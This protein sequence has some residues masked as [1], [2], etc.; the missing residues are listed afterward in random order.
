MPFKGVVKITTFKNTL[1]GAPSDFENNCGFSYSRPF[2]FG[3]L[4]F[5]AGSLQSAES[6]L[7]NSST[8]PTC[9]YVY[10]PHKI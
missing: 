5:N 3:A 2:L 1:C 9:V 7:F 10:T 4:R 6:V 8:L